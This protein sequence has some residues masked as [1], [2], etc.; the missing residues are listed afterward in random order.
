MATTVEQ[1]ATALA[2][3]Y[4]LIAVLSPEEDRIE[5]LLGRFAAGAKPQALPVKVWNC[6]E[7]FA[8]QADSTDPIAALQ[9]DRPLLGNLHAEPASFAFPG[10]D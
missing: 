3:A 10:R 2:S 7:G 9:A 6:L 8:G 4:P 5:T 1:V